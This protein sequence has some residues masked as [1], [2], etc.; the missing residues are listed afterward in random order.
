M[1]ILFLENQRRF[2]CV[3]RFFFFLP[4]HYS[5]RYSILRVLHTRLIS[6]R[7]CL[8][9]CDNACHRLR[10][11]LLV[12]FATPITTSAPP[13]TPSTPICEEDRGAVSLYLAAFCRARWGRCSLFAVHD[14]RV[15]GSE[16]RSAYTIFL[17]YLPFSFPLLLFSVLSFVCLFAFLV[18]R[19]LARLDWFGLRR[20]LNVQTDNLAGSRHI[21]FPTWTVQSGLVSISS[22]GG[23][24]VLYLQ[25]CENTSRRG[26]AF[27]MLLIPLPPCLAFARVVL[28][29]A[30]CAT[31][32][33]SPDG[34][35]VCLCRTECR[36]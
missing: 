9:A 22:G 20:Q 17:L 3:L 31:L 11:N 35:R 33:T 8:L 32:Q 23:V 6:S 14:D 27:S 25:F 16:D 7:L 36:P 15:R 2:L 19:E 1:G 21:S 30:V 24:I 12:T 18:R 10:S 5:R 13:P 4:L 34:F 29:W 26:G 28:R